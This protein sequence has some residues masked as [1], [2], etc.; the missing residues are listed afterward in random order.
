LQG[1]QLG[2]DERNTLDRILESR[3]RLL[4]VKAQLLLHR[5][6]KRWLIAHVATAS[7]LIVLVA[8]HIVTAL[9]LL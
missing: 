7:A 5:R 2:P 6:L 3:C 4:D 1:T 9:T 8:F